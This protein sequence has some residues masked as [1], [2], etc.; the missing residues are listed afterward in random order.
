MTEQVSHQQE[1]VAAIAQLEHQHQEFT[2]HLTT[3]Q[4]QVQE[5][6][7]YRQELQQFVQAAEPK[8]Q[9]V[10]QGSRSLQDAIA[11]MQQQISA[12]HTELYQLEAQI[13]DR[14]AEKQ[15]LDQTIA[16]LQQQSAAT[17]SAIPNGNRPAQGNGNGPVLP[18]TPAASWAK[19]LGS[20]WVT[21]RAQLQGCELEALRAIVLEESPAS[22]LKHL[23]EEYLTMPELLIDGINERALETIGDI[24]LEPG[25]S[26]GDTI[27][28]EEYR[29]QVATLIASQA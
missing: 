6:E 20:E 4:V 18:A 21:F 25:S 24:I 10:E 28:A 13:L 11:Q 5:L 2:A 16:F 1:L 29:N 19:G 27:V 12:L 15:E 23:A 3:L 7:Q 26:T 17:V 9:E 14:R 22:T 8:H